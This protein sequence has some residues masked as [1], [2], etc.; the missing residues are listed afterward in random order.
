MNDAEYYIYIFDGVYRPYKKTILSKIYNI[1][2]TY[3]FICSKPLDH[4]ILKFNIKTKSFGNHHEYM[5]NYHMINS[6]NTFCFT[7]LDDIKKFN[8]FIKNNNL[9]EKINTLIL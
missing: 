8:I 9:K 4:H 6:N 5:I 1:L 2:K 7:T 3:D